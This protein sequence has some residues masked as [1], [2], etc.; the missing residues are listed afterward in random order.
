MNDYIVKPVDPDRL[1][2][3]LRRWMQTSQ[4]LPVCQPVKNAAGSSVFDGQLAGLPGIDLENAL[5]CFQ[6]NESL[7]KKMFI[8]FYYDFKSVIEKIRDHLIKKEDQQV[9]FLLHSLKGVAGTLSLNNVYNEVI[10]LEAANQTKDEDKVYSNLDRLSETLQPLFEIVKTWPNS[11]E[12]SPKETATAG[13]Q[14][15]AP[16]LTEMRRKIIDLDAML[17]IHNLNARN[18]FTHIRSWVYKE[19][20]QPMVNALQSKLDRLD[21]KGARAELVLFARALGIELNAEKENG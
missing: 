13:V 10:A 14:P 12:I 7:L 5:R 2:T 15:Q 3:V 20:I 4:S 11:A 21:F 1:L 9:K 6:G 18:Y 17:R 16:D 8:H 19:N